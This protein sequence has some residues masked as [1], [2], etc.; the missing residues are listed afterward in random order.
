MKIAENQFG[1]FIIQDAIDLFGY[2][3]CEKLI[4]SILNNA[5]YFALQKYASNVIDK[6]AIVVRKHSPFLYKKLIE[7]LILNQSNLRILVENKYGM[8]VLGNLAQ[9]MSR[10]EKTTIKNLIINSNCNFFL[11]NSNYYSSFSTSNSKLSKFL[12]LLS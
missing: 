4:I 7:I 12:C 3:N 2:K 10:Q 6:I 5:V 8:F 1:N 9:L 11:N